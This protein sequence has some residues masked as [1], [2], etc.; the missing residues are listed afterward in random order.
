MLNVFS[1]T[2]VVATLA[3]GSRP[4]QGLARMR[5]KK[6]SQGAHLILLK[7]QKS[8][9]EWTFTLPS[10]FPLWE[11]ESRWIPE[12]S[13]SDW[14]GRN[15]LDW[16]VFYIIGKLLKLRCLK[17]ACM[18]YLDLKHKLWL[19]VKNWPNFLIY[20]LCATYLLKSSQGGLQLCFRPHLNR[21]SEHKV[22]GPQSCG[23][24]NF[25]NFKTPIWEFQD[26]MPFG[27]G[28]RGEA[29]SIL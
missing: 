19:K 11:F 13:E 15:P 24:P 6:E 18:T 27:C 9:R 5:D 22:M 23:S 21:R 29:Q 25:E 3:L 26:K 12:S 20:R 28:P 4:R 8:V 7:V 10:D 16:R 2:H 14:R 17:W 1:V